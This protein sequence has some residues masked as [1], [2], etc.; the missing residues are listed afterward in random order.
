MSG[1]PI[2]TLGLPAV[3]SV[4]LH[5][6][7]LLS[8]FSFILVKPAQRAP[9]TRFLPVTVVAYSHAQRQHG[10]GHGT[11]YGP[12]HGPGKNAVPLKSF[13]L[14]PSFIRKGLFAQLSDGARVEPKSEG[15]QEAEDLLK[16]DVKAAD[17]F[18][19]LAENI[20]IALDYP[21][22]LTE[23][24]V[25]GETSVDV[26]FDSHGVIDERRSIVRGDR[27][28]LRGAMVR[29]VR[30]GLVNWYQSA[31]AQL[32]ANEYRN[33]HFRADFRL[34]YGERSE[35]R[36]DRLAAGNYH[37]LRKRQ[38]DI[39]VYPGA[40]DVACAAAKVAG[41]IKK[42]TSDK[43]NVHIAAVIEALES[44][45]QQGLSGLAEVI[46]GKS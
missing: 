6:L 35:D 18:D 34:V 22:I 7:A 8:G 5:F 12:G 2:R 11:G 9:T 46:R 1:S 19:R 4:T 15:G 30:T 14:R 32:D 13:D 45:D 40:I 10:L 3:I 28:T 23:Q 44:F 25:Q 20:G 43:Y 39:C 17:I 21:D 27:G 31:A 16:G 24:G 37:F 42:K 29:A 26:Y 38:I 41:F 33:Q 36:L